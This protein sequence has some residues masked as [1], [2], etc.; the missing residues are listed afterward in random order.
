VHESNYTWF[1][2]ANG[3]FFHFAQKKDEKTCFSRNRFKRV[4]RCFL[5]V[6]IVVDTNAPDTSKKS[7]VERSERFEYF[8]ATTQFSQNSWY[9][10]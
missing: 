2:C 1:F 5:A 9:G 3:D 7:I 10:I 6:F 4:L 8:R